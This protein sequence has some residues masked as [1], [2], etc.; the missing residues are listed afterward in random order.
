MSLFEKYF[1]KKLNED[2]VAGSGGVF[3][4]TSSHG[5]AFPGGSDWWASGDARLP[6]FL[7]AK[8]KKSKKKKTKESIQRR[9]LRRTL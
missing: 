7:G 1:Y 9:N 6:V 8:K 5:G 2:N 3:G 4:A